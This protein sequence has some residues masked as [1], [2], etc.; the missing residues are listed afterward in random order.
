MLLQKDQEPSLLRILISGIDALL[1]EEMFLAS[2]SL[3]HTLTHNQ[4]N[5][6]DCFFPHT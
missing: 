5:L 2:L 4:K 1:F 3:T 6:P